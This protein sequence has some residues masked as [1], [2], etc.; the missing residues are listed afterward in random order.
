MTKYLSYKN[1][2]FLRYNSRLAVSLV[3]E[4]W[5]NFATFVDKGI[6]SGDLQGE[7]VKLGHYYDE[8]R[9]RKRKVNEEFKNLNLSKDEKYI[10]NTSIDILSSVLKK[11]YDIDKPKSSNRFTS[12]KLN[13]VFPVIEMFRGSEIEMENL[14]DHIKNVQKERI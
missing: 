11:V 1:K 4:N 12:K 2:S 6:K 9:D 14:A 3:Q 7:A 13:S 5:D 8:V 10:I